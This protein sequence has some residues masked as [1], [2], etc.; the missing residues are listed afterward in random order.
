MPIENAE[1]MFRQL[2]KRRPFVPFAVE[3]LDGRRI[4]VEHRYVAING[5][6]AGFLSKEHGIVDIV[7]DQIRRFASL[8]PELQP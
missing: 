1:E 5:N 7:F 8:T 2:I 3:M 4:I 6:G